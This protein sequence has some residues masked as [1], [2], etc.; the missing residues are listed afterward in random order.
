MQSF[1]LNKGYKTRKSLILLRFQRLLILLFPFA[2]RKR[3]YKHAKKGPK[4]G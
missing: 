1:L 2:E 3:Q 4:H